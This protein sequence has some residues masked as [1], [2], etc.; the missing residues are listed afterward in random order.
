LT[1]ILTEAPKKEWKKARLAT[2]RENARV[3]MIENPDKPMS[4]VLPLISRP[5]WESLSKEAISNARSYYRW[6][7]DNG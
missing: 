3:I 1:H 4:E 6:L 7:V 2:K 5:N